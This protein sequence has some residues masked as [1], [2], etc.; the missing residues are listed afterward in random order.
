MRSQFGAGRKSGYGQEKWLWHAPLDILDEGE[1]PNFEAP[2]ESRSKW[3]ASVE[4]WATMTHGQRQLKKDTQVRPS[5]K[6]TRKRDD[7][8]DGFSETESPLQNK[9]TI[10]WRQV[11]DSS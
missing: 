6:T 2:N 10:K 7:V 5:P 4:G 9:W 1:A 8:L 3:W 11:G